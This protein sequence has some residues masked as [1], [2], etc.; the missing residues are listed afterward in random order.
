[1]SSGTRAATRTPTSSSAS[2]SGRRS[3]AGAAPTSTTP[4]T[5]GCTSSSRSSW[6]RTSARRSSTGCSRSS[7]RNAPTSL[8]ATSKGLEAYDTGKRIG[9]VGPP[10]AERWV[11]YTAQR[12]RTQHLRAAQGGRWRSAAAGSAAAPSRGSSSGRSWWS[13]SAAWLVLRSRR[14]GDRP[15]KRSREAGRTGRPEGVS[16]G[17]PAT[18][19][20]R[21]GLRSAA[22]TDTPI[23]CRRTKELAVFRDH[24]RPPGGTCPLAVPP[25]RQP[26]LLAGTG[27]GRLAEPVHRADDA[28]LRLDR[29]PRLAQALHRDHA[30]G[31]Q[32]PQPQLRPADQGR[33]C[34]VAAGTEPRVELGASADGKTG[35]S[36][37]CTTPPGR[38][39]FRSRLVT[40][41]SP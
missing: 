38:T 33:P 40:S 29:D 13:A 24:I 8:S 28:A 12:H 2:S 31:L 6:T 10:V 7:T 18:V 1:M 41:P 39:A 37:W 9:S 26:V 19:K 14:R 34:H 3:A 27:C 4:R 20:K 25:P 23:A 16:E 32:D 36:P 11:F 30:G 5:T 22:S 35:P 17:R 21:P 15:R